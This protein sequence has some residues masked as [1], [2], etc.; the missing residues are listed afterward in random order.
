MKGFL[1]T[2]DRGLKDKDGFV[3][4]TGRLKEQINRGGE[5]IMPGEIDSALLS[6]PAVAEAVSYGAPHQLLGQ[7]VHAAV[8]LKAGVVSDAKL[9]DD[10]KKHV[11]AQIAAFKV[12][13]VVHITE[14]IPRT[15]TGKIQRRFVA[16][17]FNKLVPKL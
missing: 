14:N 2:G 12:P 1:R 15:A 7:T 6:H 16:E 8:K 9:V 10:I 13:E 3:I 17:H 11:R 5:K 4:I